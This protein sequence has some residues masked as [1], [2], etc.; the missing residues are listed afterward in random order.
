MIGKVVGNYRIVRE[1]GVGA[2]GSVYEGVDVMVER[3][4]AIKMLRAEIA[5]QPDL[6]ERFRVEA[7]TL[8]K[9]NHPNI[10]TLYAFFREGE[11]FYMVMEFVRGRTLEDVI[12]Q[13]GR[14][15]AA[16][17]ADILS[18][19]LDGMAHAHQLGILHRD[20][21]PAN[22]MITAEGRVK[23]TDFGIARVLGSS[24]MTREGRIIGTLEY[25]APERIKGEET[26]ARSDLYSAG[27]V[28]YEALSG[29]LPFI[30][31]T[32]FALM[33]AHL[34]TAPPPLATIGI[35]CP[36]ELEAILARA[37]AKAPGDRFQSAG[38]FR[39]ALVSFMPAKPTATAAVAGMKPTRLAAPEPALA[40]TRLV[41]TSGVAA[42]PAMARAAGALKPATTLPLKW[43]GLA[44]AAVLLLAGGMVG[45]V[46]MRRPVPQTETVA[47]VTPPPAVQQPPVESGSPLPGTITDQPPASIAQVPQPGESPVVVPPQRVEQTPVPPANRR[48]AA[49][50][51]TPQPAET[52]AVAAGGG[53]P[54]PPV[55]YPAAPAPAPPP[56][57][58]LPAAE[59]PAAAP[60]PTVHRTAPQS[61]RD[62]HKLYIEQMP[63]DLKEYV[64]EEISKQM[65][66]R[67]LV[68]RRPE[69]ADA[70]MS[71]RASADD[72]LGSKV[73]GGY[74]GMKDKANATASITDVSRNVMLWNSQAGDK[75]PI[76]GMMRRGGV[77]KVAE[78]LVS[79][80]RK[81]MEE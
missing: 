8:A 34:E 48:P 50:R 76:L 22:I 64:V 19:T 77:K 58:A 68:V 59:P 55:E 71:G 32:D 69:D 44:L 73:T 65:R 6:I 13:S 52:E 53:I 30:S 2:M 66:G 17:V 18:Q 28:L 60:A 27:I 20:I 25:I 81:A 15:P 26:D 72:G 43:I 40:P 3:R 74:L 67:L 36:P 23:V 10:A 31:S 41:G 63:E 70:I 80:L 47:V 61:I 54:S 49:V 56:P 14:L 39:D 42:A 45:I 29:R 16:T 33:Q 4:V 37:L 38:E 79:N 21:K 5:R 51:K 7:V 9:L 46:W 35:D 78:R 1:L 57:V 75:T 24:R 11:D 12:E 62:V